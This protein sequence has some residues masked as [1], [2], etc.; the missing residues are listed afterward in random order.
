M[1]ATLMRA[2]LTSK[3]FSL[4]R[5]CLHPGIRPRVR[6]R[7]SHAIANA[8]RRLHEASGSGKLAVFVVRVDTFD[9]P[10]AEQLLCRHQ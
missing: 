3:P 10:K 9:K 7:G 6:E 4:A 2:G 8:D 5:A 1:G